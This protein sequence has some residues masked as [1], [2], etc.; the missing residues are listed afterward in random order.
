MK[1]ELCDGLEYKAPFFVS[2]KGGGYGGCLWEPNFFMVDGD[3]KFHDLLSSGYK[4]V[5]SLDG[6]TDNHDFQ[7][8][9]FSDNLNVGKSAHENFSGHLVGKINEL[10]PYSNHVAY[11]KCSHCEKKL[12]FSQSDH[13]S[14]PQWFHDEQ[15]Y[16]GNGGI[17]VNF[18]S[19]LCEDCYLNRC[20]ECDVI[21][22]KEEFESCE[23]C[24]KQ[25]IEEREET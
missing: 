18:H 8:T 4:A 23:Y 7:V 11:V 24:E 17:G 19:I 10:Y 16:S 22:S 15:N 12:R 25:K 20:E 3:G 6:V 14:Y 5:K 13:E 21:L 2:Y 9:E 1:L